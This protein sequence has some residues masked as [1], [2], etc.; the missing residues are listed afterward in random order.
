MFGHLLKPVGL[1][2]PLRSVVEPVI[3][4]L[5]QKFGLFATVSA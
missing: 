5:V 4:A 2:A 3:V 1:E